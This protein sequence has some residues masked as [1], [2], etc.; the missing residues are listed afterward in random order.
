[1]NG[2]NFTRSG[3]EG[4]HLIGHGAVHLS[5]PNLFSTHFCQRDFEKKGTSIRKS[6]YLIPCALAGSKPKS[7]NRMAARAYGAAITSFAGVASAD[8]SFPQLCRAAE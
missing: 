7:A 4:K 1:M 6:A 5:N 2:C 8:A 3:D